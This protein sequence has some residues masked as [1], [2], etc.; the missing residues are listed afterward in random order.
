MEL[1]Y[2]FLPAIFHFSLSLNYVFTPRIK[3][4][5]KNIKY[6][7]I[8]QTANRGLNV[9]G[10]LGSPLLLGKS[11][12]DDLFLRLCYHDSETLTDLQIP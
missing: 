2:F 7:C 6:P 4:E 9:F 12:G 8:C 5:L 1:L 3:A 11:G 10:V